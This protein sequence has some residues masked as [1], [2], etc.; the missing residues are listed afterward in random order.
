MGTGNQKNRPVLLLSSML[1]WN[2]YS[3]VCVTDWD[4]YKSL[5]LSERA[6]S[7]NCS[8]VYGTHA[9]QETVLEPSDGKFMW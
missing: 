5:L 6:S 3:V 1:P 9:L 8:V 2:Y 7:H 4:F